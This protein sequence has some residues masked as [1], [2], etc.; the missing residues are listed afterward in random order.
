M[1]VEES[2]TSVPT[3]ATH[4]GAFCCLGLKI[5]SLKSW[6]YFYLALVWFETSLRTMATSIITIWLIVFTQ[7]VSAGIKGEAVPKTTSDFYPR[8]LNWLLI[9]NIVFFFQLPN[10][11]M[12][13]HLLQQQ[14]KR[15]ETLKS[16]SLLLH[17][18]LKTSKGVSISSSPL[19]CSLGALSFSVGS[20]KSY[21][22]PIGSSLMFVFSCFMLL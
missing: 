21:H 15:L 22:Q 5:H 14:Q 9:Q 6:W 18:L 12:Q 8:R 2:I 3:H 13:N 16:W 4:T 1:I 17:T 7:V 11:K 19:V 20:H 10:F